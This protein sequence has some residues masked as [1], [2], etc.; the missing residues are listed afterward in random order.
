MID[1]RY[2]LVSMI[3]V[4]LALAVGLIVGVTALSGP[5]QNILNGELNRVRGTNNALVKDKQDLNNEQ[6]ANQSFA[7]ASAPLLLDHLLT[8][9]NVV[10]VQ[11]PNPDPAVTNGVM[12]ALKLAGANITGEVNLST[13]FMDT[14]VA[15]E[16][17]LTS[18]ATPVASTAG[19]SLPSQS[20]DPAVSGQQDAAAV[21]AAA[22]LDTD[23]T[24]L[25]TSVSETVLSPFLSGNY[26]LFSNL[27]GSAQVPPPATMAVLVIP[28][29]TA[30]TSSDGADQVLTAVAQELKAYGEAT[31]M[32]GPAIGVGSGSAIS[33][34][35]SAPTAGQV[36]TV[37]FADTEAGQ[38]QAVQ[39]LALARD[40]QPA[41]AYGVESGVA[42]SPAPTPSSSTTTTTPP[43]TT[44]KKGGAKKK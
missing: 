27:P 21:I 35:N 12:A 4:F 1:F 7:Q 29:G 9:Q 6:N 43:A 28:G 32:V 23:G 17:S 16:D 25:K 3:A 39:A 22:I 26:L 10:L 15:T 42:P 33:A 38:I 41:K 34:E 11:A 5:A 40:G 30:P 2:H 13:K 8:G 18:L 37:D 19:V 31:V 24:G 44:T 36:S 14:N 20:S